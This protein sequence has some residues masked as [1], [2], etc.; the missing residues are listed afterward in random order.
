MP[1]YFHTWLA[2]R[3]LA[4]QQSV[5]QRHPRVW[6]EVGLPQHRRQTAARRRQDVKHTSCDGRLTASVSLYVQAGA[7]LRRISRS[8]A[9]AFRRRR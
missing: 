6:S 3:K 5:E 7:R 9:C 8:R 1:S 4:L 2:M